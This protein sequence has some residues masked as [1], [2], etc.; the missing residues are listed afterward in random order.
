MAKEIELSVVIPAYNEEEGI[1]LFHQSL[2]VPH[3]ISATSDYEIIYVDDGSEDKTL[4]VLSSVA[5]EDNRVKVVSLSR[6]FG[7][8]VASSAGIKFATGKA[9]IIIDSDGQHPPEL[10]PEFVKKWKAGAQVVVGVRTSNQREGIL[11]KWG[12]TL[13]YRLLNHVNDVHMKPGSTDYRLIDQAVQKEFIKLH[14]HNRIT[15]GLIDWLGFK[16]DYIYF[17]APPRLAGK[18]TYS[19]TKLL[20]LAI[21]SLASLSIKPLFVLAWIGFFV[22]LASFSLGVFIMVEQFLFNDPM[23]LNFTGAALL[24]IFISFLVG[25]VLTSQGVIAIYLSH[26]HT[27]AQGRPLYIVDDSKSIGV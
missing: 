10:I 24:G 23:H 17:E 27:H 12:S 6:N 18:A 15:R 3:I 22:T 21:N 14:E 1:K 20:G 11:K 7:K 8:E 13:F 25:L 5:E 19:P 2:L 4:D 16:R 26:V 9:I